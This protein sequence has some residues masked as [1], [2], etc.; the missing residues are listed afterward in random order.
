T[1]ESMPVVKT[2]GATVYAGTVLLSGSVRVR[3][4]RVGSDTAVGRLIRRVEEARE[5]RAP[6]QTVGDEFSR[7]FVPASF[8]L[9]VAVL[10]LT[11]DARRALTRLLI[12]CPCAVGLA[13][14][15]AVSAAIGNGARRGVLIKGGAHLEAAARLDAIVFDKTGT[16]T[17]GIPAVQRVI[18]LVD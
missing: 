15:T 8:A 18:A 17:E 16:L 5:L 7:R 1:G 9:A 6:I 4:E 14:P 2:A 10:L 13:T 12:A 3:V 11:G